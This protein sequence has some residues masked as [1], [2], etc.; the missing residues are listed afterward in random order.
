MNGVVVELQ[1]RI[2]T[3]R[4]VVP[5]PA[6]LSY[7]DAIGLIRDLQDTGKKR[8]ARLKRRRA[9]LER[10]MEER[11]IDPHRP[12]GDYDAGEAS[13]LRWAIE[14]LDPAPTQAR[15]NRAT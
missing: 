5:C 8:L 12:P 3:C 10:R 1:R 9:F 2:D 11:G 7:G 13:A 4:C 15:P 6:C 14:Q